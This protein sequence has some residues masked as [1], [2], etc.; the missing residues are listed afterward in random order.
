MKRHF[1]VSIFQ[2]P[3]EW[4]IA[5]KLERNYTKE[6]IIA[7]YLSYFDFSSSV[8][9]QVNSVINMAID[10]EGGNLSTEIFVSMKTQ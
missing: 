7:L 5:V 1:D 9:E 6:E 3:I 2:K 4:V 8:K 10:V